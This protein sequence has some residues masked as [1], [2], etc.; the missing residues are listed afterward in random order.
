MKHPLV[1]CCGNQ[2]RLYFY[3][4]FHSNLLWGLNAFKYFKNLL[5]QIKVHNSAAHCQ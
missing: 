4:S 2:M 5:N 1:T 3:H